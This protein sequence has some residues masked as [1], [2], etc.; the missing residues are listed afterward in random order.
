[1]GLR[2][3]GITLLLALVA[4]L[5][6][7]GSAHSSAQ[8]EPSYQTPPLPAWSAEPAAIDGPPGS[9]GEHPEREPGFGT[10]TGLEGE[11]LTETPQKPPV[12]EKIVDEAP[13]EGQNTSTAPQDRGTVA[14]PQS[15]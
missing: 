12:P 7:A 14:P 13:E 4:D 15:D 1:M 11:W 10:E 8:P 9:E 5:G 3:V 6:C 2:T